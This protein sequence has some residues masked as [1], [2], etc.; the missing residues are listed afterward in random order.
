MHYHVN[1]DA[2]IGC[3]LC[4]ETCPEVFSLRDDGFA[5]AGARPPCRKTRRRLPPRPW[6]PARR[7]RS[8]RADKG[9]KICYTGSILS[10]GVELWKNVMWRSTWKR[11]TRRTGA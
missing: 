2:C 10:N 11:R 6:T 3:G 8:K 7:A 9:R 1:E 5:E 4:A